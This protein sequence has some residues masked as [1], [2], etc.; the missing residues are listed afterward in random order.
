[1]NNDFQSWLKVHLERIE[2]ALQQQLPSASELPHRLH[3]AMLYAVQAGGKRIRPLLIYAAAEVGQAHQQNLSSI[4][5]SC[6][7]IEFLHTYS[8]V[9]DDLPCM[10]NDDLRRGKPTTHKAFDE[11]TAML[12]GDALQTQAFLVLSQ[13]SLEPQLRVELIQELAAASGS[14]GMAGGQAIDLQSVGQILH[15]ADLERMH[16][17]KT[18]ALLRA[19]VRMGAIL[20]GVDSEHRQALD[21][22]A[23]ALGLCFQVIDDVLDATGDS[24]TLGKTAG[25][26]AQADKPTF[27]SLMG[28]AN[29]KKFADDLSAQAL[30]AVSPLG[31]RAQAL[32]DIAQWVTARQH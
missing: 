10:D 20:G 1:M 31:P 23:Q 24:S 2:K 12:V 25:K 26:D 11:A 7:A 13:L 21:V 19:A 5:A 18:G 17:M 9:H 30:G 4:D 8:L 16:Q 15:Q 27:V 3:E 28:L 22:Y 29:A 14:L 6:A 32:I